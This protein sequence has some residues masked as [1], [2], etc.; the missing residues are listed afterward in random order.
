[1]GVWSDFCRELE[2]AGA[3]VDRPESPGDEIDR[4]EGY[5]YLT[6]LLRIGLDL[7]VEF[8]D[9]QHPELVPAQAKHFGDGGNTADCIYLHAVLD[10]RL[11]YRLRGT[12]GAA[13]LMEI[14]LYAGKIGLDPTSRRVDA[15]REDELVVDRDGRIDV[16]IGDQN[17]RQD[18]AASAPNVLHGDETANYLF[19]RQYAHDWDRTEPAS[20]RLE[21]VDE[22][23]DRVGR[24]HAPLTLDAVA[25]GL[26]RAARFVHDAGEA[27]AAVVDNARRGPANV[28]NVVPDDM[29]MTLPS[30]H[31]F[32]FGHF[33]LADHEALLVEFQP[34]DVPYWGLTINNYWFEVL[35]YGERGSHLNNRT[36]VAEP[37]A[38]V[39]VVISRR[40]PG[41]ENWIDTRGHRVGALVFRWSRTPL[42]VP[43]LACRVVPVDTLSGRSQA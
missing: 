23:L 35:D 33:D 2:R 13:P 18:D 41:H 32:A 22:D 7:A 6:R 17:D 27:W 26:R 40:R 10:A 24:V 21:L 3:L 30:G 15:L 37:D 1:V 16:A 28:F 5:R 20:L 29:D 11:R 4:A 38:T 34:L 14:G 8:A 19:I 36:A 42:P 43:E 12:R 9:P 31:R 25:G 39:R